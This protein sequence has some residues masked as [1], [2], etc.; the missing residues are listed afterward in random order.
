MKFVSESQAAKQ[1]NSGAGAAM[2]ILY[3]YQY[4]VILLLLYVIYQD[5][6]LEM[7]WPLVLILSIAALLFE[8]WFVNRLKNYIQHGQVKPTV[9]SG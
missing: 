1:V 8:L 5:L 2:K 7:A 4:I 9:V 6:S 3:Y